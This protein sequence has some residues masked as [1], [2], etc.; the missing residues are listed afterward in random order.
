MA[1]LS[2]TERGIVAAR[3]RNLP[4]DV[5]L[6][7]FTQTFGCET[8]ADTGRILDELASISPRIAVEEVNLVLDRDRVEA[9][10]VDRAPA[11]V[12][13]RRNDD[14][15]EWTPGVRFYGIPAGYEFMALLEAIELVASGDSGLAPE[16]RSL[17]AAVTSPMRIQVFTTPT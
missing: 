6:L 3:F 11:I 1:L 8:C 16:T 12:L 17:V 2:D 13:A 14:G 4:H 15:T 9:M 10:G 5:R 7:F